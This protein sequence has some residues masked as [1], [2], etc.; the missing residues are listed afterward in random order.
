MKTALNTKIGIDVRK[1]TPEVR[2]HVP[3]LIHD[4]TMKRMNARHFLEEE[5]DKVL[6]DIHLLLKSGNHQ[7]KWEAA[8]AL[9]DIA[10]VRAIPELIR[11]MN[12]KES[13]FRWMAAEGL[14][15]LGRRSI[16]PLLELVI[17][18]GQSPRIRTGAHYVLNEVLTDI[19]KL[20]MENLMEALS[21]YYETGETA[22]VWASEA[23]KHFPRYDA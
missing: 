18:K 14:R 19:E 22:P 2:K 1:L 16:V 17:E 3:D 20:E 12:D 15:K 11:L 10:S 21:N 5:G 6:D 23:I 8:K 4:K 13:E 7:L 9:E